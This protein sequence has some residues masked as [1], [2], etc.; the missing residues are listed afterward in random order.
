VELS[1]AI[2]TPAWHDEARSRT[3][4]RGSPFTPPSAAEFPNSCSPYSLTN[5]DRTLFFIAS[6]DTHGRE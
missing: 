3:R 4:G 1:E 6:D 2:S 5:V